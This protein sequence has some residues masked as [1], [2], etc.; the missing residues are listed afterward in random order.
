METVPRFST[1]RFIREG[2]VTHLKLTRMEC[3]NAYNCC[4]GASHVSMGRET[5]AKQV[6]VSVADCE[7]AHCNTR[8]FQVGMSCS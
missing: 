7:S 1:V 6:S 5:S 3:W 4:S 8:S 2:C